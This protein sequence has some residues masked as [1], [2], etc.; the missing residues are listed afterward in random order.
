MQQAVRLAI[1]YLL[2]GSMFKKIFH[3]LPLVL[4]LSACGTL[5][6]GIYQTPTPAQ[7]T[8]AEAT[9]TPEPI[10]KPETRQTST[11]LATETLALAAPSFSDVSFFMTTGETPDCAPRSQDIFPAYIRQVHARWNYANMRA[12]LTIRRE[13]YHNGELWFQ[14]DQA[15]DFAKYGKDGVIS[16]ISIYDFDAGL[17]PGKYE[18]RLYINGQPQFNSESKI[19]FLAD[20]TQALETAAPNGLLTAIIADPQ[21]LMLREADGTQWELLRAHSISKLEWF[22]D[23]RHIVY[24]DTDHSQAQGCSSIGIRYTLWIVDTA[25][26]QQHQIGMDNENLHTPML[27]PDERY[28]AA[29]SGSGYG[30]ACMIDLRLVFVELDNNLY[31]VQHF[32]HQI[33][34]GFPG[35][36]PDSNSYPSLRDIAGWQDTTHF[37]TGLRWT[38]LLQNDDLSGIYLFD[39]AGRQVIRTGNLSNP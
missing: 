12:G 1:I 5:E 33:F 31:E 28:I 18:L 26:G 22:A 25:T 8:Q 23:S 2:E 24:S 29:L 27:S 19:S 16:D 3:L 30:D 35:E 36:M 10:Q 20:Q 38:C 6:V 11:Q 7:P 37:K 39:L 32:S 34:A 13:W 17:G 21:K 9:S 4:L 15:W 14:G